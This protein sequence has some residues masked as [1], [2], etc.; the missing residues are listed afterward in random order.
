MPRL[1]AGVRVP[2]WLLCREFNLWPNKKHKRPSGFC[3]S[4][5]VYGSPSWEDFCSSILWLCASRRME[6]LPAQ[7]VD[8]SAWKQ[9][10]RVSRGFGKPWGAGAVERGRTGELHVL[11]EM[12]LSGAAKIKMWLPRDFWRATA[13]RVPVNNSINGTQNKS[14]QVQQIFRSFKKHR[15]AVGHT[16]PPLRWV[17]GFLSGHGVKLTTYVQLMLSLRMSGAMCSP[18]R[19]RGLHE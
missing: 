8:T 12:G 19:P 14:L 4:V 13:A 11:R 16:Q 10:A 15:P 18:V 6:S 2:F 1:R 7:L 5:S 3:L 17:S 9:L